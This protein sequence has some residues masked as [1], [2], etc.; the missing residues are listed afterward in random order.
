MARRRMFAD[1]TELKMPSAGPSEYLH[2]CGTR[3]KV[4]VTCFIQAR[5]YKST[6]RKF[7]ERFFAS[8]I[9]LCKF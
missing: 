3:G 8:L 9:P 5:A 7:A 4:V 6:H 2:R 1:A